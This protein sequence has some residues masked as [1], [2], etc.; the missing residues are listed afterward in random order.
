MSTQL[1]DVAVSDRPGEWGHSSARGPPSE[2]PAAPVE[3]F[4]LAF[5]LGGGISAAAIGFAALAVWA[6]RRRAPG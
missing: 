5:Y 3:G 1:I 6:G 4:Q 2:Q